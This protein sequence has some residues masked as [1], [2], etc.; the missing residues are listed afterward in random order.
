MSSHV[1]LI[2]RGAD[3]S[4]QNINLGS[5]LTLYYLT[6]RQK[7]DVEIKRGSSKISLLAGNL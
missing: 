4:R 3:E 1:Y 6:E 2:E 5:K 7:F